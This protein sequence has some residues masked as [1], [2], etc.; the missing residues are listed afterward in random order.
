MRGE[1]EISPAF[2][3]AL[4]AFLDYL[5]AE[6]GLSERT[7]AA[8]RGDLADFA[9]FAGRHGISE[10]GGVRRPTVTLY[11]V[12]LRRRALKPTTVARR[13]AAVRSFYR[14][15]VRERSVSVDPTED[16][17]SPKRGERLPKVLSVEEVGWLLAQPDPRTPEGLRDRA[18][19]ELLY[20]CGLR[21]SELVGLDVGDVD[22]EA[23][24][25]RVLGKGDRERVVPLG[26]YAVRALQAYLQLARPRLAGRSQALFVARSGGRLSRQWVWKL[27]RRYAHKAGIARAVTPHVLRH[28]FATHLLE[29]GADLRSVQELL[30]HASVS[31][32]QVYTHVARPHLVEVF[33]RSHPRDGWGPFPQRG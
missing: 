22:L 26:S 1:S 5:A 31:T 2:Q 19:L 14:F 13:L 9:A 3:K 20:G 15:L 25:V 6:V 17:T 28:S 12:D 8:Y 29:G 30:G 16:V 18:I 7:R 11:L 21:V 4:D 27:L 10:P 33:E 32:T 23:E 24:L